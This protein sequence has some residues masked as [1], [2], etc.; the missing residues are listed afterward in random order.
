M[1]DGNPWD[2]ETPVRDPCSCPPVLSLS[3]CPCPPYLSFFPCPVYPFMHPSILPSIR[4]S[5]RPSVH[6][7]ICP[8][9]H[10]SMHPLTWLDQQCVSAWNK[11]LIFLFRALTDNTILHDPVI[12]SYHEVDEEAVEA[13]R[14]ML[15]INTSFQ[16]LVLCRL[17]LTDYTAEDIA[18]ML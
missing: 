11:S 3:S 5:V 9:I 4:P 7:S 6:P 8:S 10:A 1:R 14:D 15:N 13:L 16:H 12:V 18:N 17:R 2:I